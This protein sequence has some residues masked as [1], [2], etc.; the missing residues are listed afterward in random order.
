MSL[1][2]K[3]THNWRP[4]V[5]MSSGRKPFNLPLIAITL[6]ASAPDH[7]RYM[8]TQCIVPWNE[9]VWALCLSSRN[10]LICCVKVLVAVE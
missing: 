10:L 7:N 9:L 4:T 8:Y 2:R 6:F 1:M 5:E 3:S